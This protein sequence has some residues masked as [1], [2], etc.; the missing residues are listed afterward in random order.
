MP[1][2]VHTLSS[3]IPL[4]KPLHSTRVTNPPATPTMPKQDQDGTRIP[5]LYKEKLKVTLLLP[6][7]AEYVQVVALFWWILEYPS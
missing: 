2:F 3:S 7:Y 1:G 6:Y 4:L 5:F